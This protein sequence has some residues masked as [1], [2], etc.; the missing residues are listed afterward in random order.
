MPGDRGKITLSGQAVLSEVFLE[1][2]VELDATYLTSQTAVLE[3]RHDSQIKMGVAQTLIGS[4]RNGGNIRYQAPEDL[5]IKIN[6]NK[7]AVQP[8]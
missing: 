3:S 6:G 7:D 8:L 1:G 4:T 5:L 2:S